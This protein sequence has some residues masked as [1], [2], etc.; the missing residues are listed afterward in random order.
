[1]PSSPSR[2][3]EEAALLKRAWAALEVGAMARASLLLA[4]HER[5]FPD[6]TLAPE[7][8]AAAAI[9]RCRSGDTNA[10][11]AFLRAVPRSIHADRVRAACEE[12]TE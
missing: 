12:T 3:R 7:R 10:G 6:G 4:R 9:L 5:E 11:A 1:M 2:L 8:R